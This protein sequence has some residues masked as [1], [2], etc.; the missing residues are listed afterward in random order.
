MGMLY[1]LDSSVAIW[2]IQRN[3]ED[4]ALRELFQHPQHTLVS[5]VLLRTE[6]I[7]TLRRDDLS[8]DIADLVL[9]YVR[10]I[11]ITPES[12]KRAEAIEQHIKTLDAIHMGEA[13]QFKGEITLLTHDKQMK[14]VAEA[15]DLPVFDP[16]E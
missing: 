2:A 14:R 10:L 15:N 1:Y 5:S 7:R 9:Q 13:L 4:Q 6:I 16:L 12:F 11:A 3:D 8:L